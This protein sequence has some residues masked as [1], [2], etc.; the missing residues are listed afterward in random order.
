MPDA[1]DYR[2]LVVDDHPIMRFGISQ[3]IQ[4]E[5]DLDIIAEA[6]TA[7]EAL[8]VLE[9]NSVHLALI[10]LSLPDRNGLELIKDIRVMYPEVHCLVVSMHD[11]SLY[12]ERVLRCGGRG[13]LRKVEAAKK[14]ISAI[15]QVLAGGIFVSEEISAR[16]MESLATGGNPGTSPVDCL[17]DREL[18]VFRLLG[19]GHGSRDVAGKL[20]ISVRTVDAHRAHIKEKLGLKD[21]T[22]L[23]HHAVRW[24]ESD[25]S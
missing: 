1:A 12:A 22:E 11:E 25:G 23:V 24:V 7:A 6:G 14:L 13:Y 9:E 16:I 8:Q 18:E 5:A 19:E 10:D 15:R 3:L 4:A 20:G 21:A 17:S 2:I